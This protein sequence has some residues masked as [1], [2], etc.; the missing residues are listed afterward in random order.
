MPS[1]PSPRF[2]AAVGATLYAAALAAAAYAP[3]HPL[4]GLDPIRYA[5][6]VVQAVS[7]LLALS[8][9]GLVWTGLSDR[10][11]A[12]RGVRPAGPASRRRLRILAALAAGALLLW[13]ARDRSHYLGDGRVWLEHLRAGSL[14]HYSEP[15]SVAI[16]QGYLGLIHAL[17]AQAGP[18]ALAWL[19]VACGLVAG[20]IFMGIVRELTM[21]EPEGSRAARPWMFGL[22][23]TSGAAMLYFGYIEVYPIVSLAVL[24]Y[25]LIGLRCLRGASSPWLAC[26][27]LT[28]AIGTHFISVFLIPSFVDVVLRSGGSPMKRIALLAAPVPMVIALLSLLGIPIGETARP[29]S[30]LSVA[31]RS[32]AGRTA[33]TGAS[34]GAM[35]ADLLSVLLL[36]LPIPLALLLARLGRPPEDRRREPAFLWLAAAPGLIAALILVIP[37][38]PAQDWDVTAVTVLP[39]LVLGVGAGF[40]VLRKASPRFGPGLAS[41]ALAGLVPFVLVNTSEAR[42]LERLKGLIR[43]GTRVSAHERAYGNEKIARTYMDRKEYA[44]ALPYAQASH[45]AEP[46]NARF[47]TNLGQV[48]QEL[49]RVDEAIPLLERAVAVAPDRWDSRY[50]LGLC[51][52]KRERYA[53]AADLLGSAVAKGGDRPDVHHLWGIALFRS[54]RR[55][56]A[57]TVWRGI[58]ERW[59]GY[60]QSLQKSG[61]G[62]APAP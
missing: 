15:L 56:S 46:N 4:W 60:A 47:L 24:A 5:T 50:D 7:L 9:L 41:L 33:P 22:L 20:L 49:G 23:A 25:L 39:L 62:G 35:L 52:M 34:I 43:P 51:Y 1:L 40:D 38:S 61:A 19:S 17:G 2:A 16:W 21:E 26:A 14:Q 18:D 27:A 54:D 8:G 53:E 55:D 11:A 42:A 57:V 44:N 12:K 59:P 45:E 37:G 29:F 30:A 31:L 6:P 58:L 36:V 48:L 32:T 28:V 10:G 3:L 13:L